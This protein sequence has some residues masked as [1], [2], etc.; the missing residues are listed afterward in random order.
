MSIPGD[1]PKIVYGPAGCGTVTA[2]PGAVT[3]GA[4]LVT[5][6]TFTGAATGWTLGTGWAYETNDVRHT[7]GNTATLAPTAALAI[8]AGQR[9]E[10]TVT[11]AGRSA[12]SITLS[13]G[14]ST[15]SALST[16]GTYT[17]RLYA[18]TTANLAVTPT[19][20]FNGDV[21]TISVKRCGM[22]DATY[23]YV[24]YAFANVNGTY[25]V[26][27]G[28]QANATTT[29]GAG[30]GKVALSWTPVEFADGYRVYEVN[31]AVTE[32]RLIGTYE[33]GAGTGGTWTASATAVTLTVQESSTTAGSLPAAACP[34]T[35][36]L[37]AKFNPFKSVP[38]DRST[39]KK[40]LTYN[41]RSSFPEQWEVDCK[42]V[43]F[44]DRSEDWDGA[45][46]EAFTTAW[47]RFFTYWAS[48]GKVFTFYRKATD[49]TMGLSYF[50]RCVW[51][52]TDDGLDRSLIG[53]VRYALQIS[54]STEG[55][56][57]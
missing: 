28:A 17:V 32:M 20:D 3:L 44:T 23:Y 19:S 54:L 26:S 16:D 15:S 42:T 2:T 49:S 52:R 4:E 47:R 40:G 13:L 36:W 43:N 53:R 8:T 1:N 50:Q 24:V 38:S 48:P 18:S 31:G 7:A 33:D 12:G 27:A 45:G 30:L 46:S 9:Y 21:D 11:I 14:G 41:Q 37:P 51:D 5:N 10:C 29:A 35:L 25:H 39:V 34:R 55:A 57:R 56:A 22:D 6:G